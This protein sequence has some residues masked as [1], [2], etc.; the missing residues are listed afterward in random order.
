MNSPNHSD[1]SSLEITS[2]RVFSA[3]RQALFDAFRDPHKLTRWWGPE[4]FTSTF[5]EFNFTADGM[6]LFTL[7]GPD[8]T[9]Y[10]N[11]VRFKEIVEPEKIVFEHIEQEHNFQMSMSFDEADSKTTVMWKMRFEKPVEPG[12][13][14]FIFVANQQNFDRLGAL[15]ESAV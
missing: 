7:H 15:L 14:A 3:R 4:G 2:T 12:V 13:R 9:D 6:W 11:V 1:T 10:P 8:G 5:R